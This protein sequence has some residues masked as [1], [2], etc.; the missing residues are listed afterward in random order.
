VLVN[1]LSIF[2]LLFLFEIFIFLVL[3]FLILRFFSKSSLLYSSIV[4]IL[5]TVSIVTT[6]SYLFISDQFS[7]FESYAVSVFGSGLG[8]IFA[9]FLYTF[10]GPATADRSLAS[11]ML[12]LL[13][14]VPDRCLS[15]EEIFDRYDSR[16][17]IEKRIDECRA[18]NII[19]ERNG[20]VILTEK[21]KKIAQLYLYLL[22]SLRLRE[23]EGYREYFRRDQKS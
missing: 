5:L 22:R 6:L 8:A 3:H 2:F 16:G 18:E 1:D 4:A 7:A 12:S 17:F 23:R 20:A 11:Q 19:E 21:G 15:R 9:G 14:D 13:N 10:L